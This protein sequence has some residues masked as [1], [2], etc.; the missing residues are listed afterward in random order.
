MTRR[1]AKVAALIQELNLGDK[2][3][4]AISQ[5]LSTRRKGAY[6]LAFY[7]TIN[8]SEAVE[9]KSIFE[10]TLFSKQKEM[11]EANNERKRTGEGI[12]EGEIQ[13]TNCGSYRTQAMAKQVRSADEA[14]TTFVYCNNCGKRMTNV[15]NAL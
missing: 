13:C 9:S 6:D 10:T 1:T 11:E 3:A 14:M 2:E 12:I 7:A 4:Q 5:I 15:A 8:P